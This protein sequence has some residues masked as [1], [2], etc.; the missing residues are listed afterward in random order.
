MRFPRRLSNGSRIVF[1]DPEKVEAFGPV[2][3]MMP[4]DDTAGLIALNARGEGS[5]VGSLV[6]HDQDFARDVV[7]GAAVPGRILVL[8]R[9]GAA[10][11]TGTASRCPNWSTADQGRSGGEEE[12][13][14]RAVLHHMQRT[15]IQAG[16]AMLRALLGESDN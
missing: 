15:A 5:L 11:S 12:G 9:D 3:T 13:G 7:L 10:E 14:L 8:D 16:S 2:S 4:Q 6:T 1:G